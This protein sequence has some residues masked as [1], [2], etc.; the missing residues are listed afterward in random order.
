MR[1]NEPFIIDSYKGNSRQITLGN[2]QGWV[3]AKPCPFTDI[4]IRLYH[5]W[6]ILTGKATAVYF[7][8]DVADKPEWHKRIIGASS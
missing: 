6:L 3:I 1:K 4:S 2:M 7:A 5:A 8:E